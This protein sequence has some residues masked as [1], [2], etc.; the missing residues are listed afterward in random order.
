MCLII[1]AIQCHPRYDLILLANRDEF[2]SRPSAQA[3]FWKEFPTLLAGRDL[4]AGGTW[5]GITMEGK[6]AAITNYRDPSLYKEKTPSRGLL[7]RDFLLNSKNAEQYLS[8][9]TERAMDYNSFNL[10]VGQRDKLFWFSNRSD[11]IRSLSSGIYGI[12]NHLLDSPWPKVV[13]GKALLE[14]LIS[15]AKELSQEEVFECLR[16]NYVPDDIDL[17]DTGVGLEQERMF[18][19]IFISSPDYGTRSS[20]M[21]LID[22]DN[23]VTFIERTYLPEQDDLSTVQYQFQIKCRC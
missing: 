6:I 10:I 13:R 20:T 2:Y 22:K 18:S 11:E 19:P 7:V 5:L 14:G 16:D 17:P 9:I 4:Q 23:R 8:D 3:R 1:L 15:K 12:S 21:L